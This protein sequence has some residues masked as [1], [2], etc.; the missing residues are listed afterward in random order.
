MTEKII[1]ENQENLQIPEVPEELEENE[2]IL[3]E[4]IPKIEPE[5]NLFFESSPESQSEPKDSKKP[6]KPHYKQTTL[7]FTQDDQK[8]K[9]ETQKRKL[10]YPIRSRKKKKKVEIIEIS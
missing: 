9:F 3:S 2:P 10:S 6:K 8:L 4:K 1:E 7:V 5:C